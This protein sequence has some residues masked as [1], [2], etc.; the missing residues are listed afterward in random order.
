MIIGIAGKMNSGKDTVASMLN[1]IIAV[2]KNN[3]KYADWLIK[4]Q[5]YDSSYQHKIT[6]FADIVKSNLA[7]I[8]NLNVDAF[9]NRHYKDELWYVP[10]TGKFI[11][12]PKDSKKWIKVS[13]N[14][15]KETDLNKPNRIIQLRTYLQVYAETCK[16][17]FGKDVWVKSTLNVAEYINTIHKICL[18]PDVRFDNEVQGIWKK[19]GII[20][21]I[22]R[23]NNEL[24]SEHI[25]EKITTLYNYEIN[26]MSTQQVLFIKVL[27]IY[28]Q[29]KDKLI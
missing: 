8:L 1:Y 21:N 4:R 29:I 2:G 24:S 3:A 25:S 11:E 20:I 28:D 7:N 17:L 13:I 12:D 22:H 18:I 26:N 10:S 14:N 15:F 16:E 27:A 6:R 19:N 9:N 23:Q 5:A